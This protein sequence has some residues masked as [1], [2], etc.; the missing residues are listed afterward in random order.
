MN[1]ISLD[2]IRMSVV[3]SAEGG[4]VSSQTIFR[5]EQTGPV[6]SARYQGGRIV[7]GYLIGRLDGARLAFRYVQAD[8]DNNLDSGASKGVL[9]RT[10]AGR[11]RLIEHFEWATRAGGG[12]NIF[13]ELD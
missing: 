9:Q 1:P 5:F 8:T 2:G 10:P 6:V 3:A 4:V 13:E 7:D 12:T 11:L